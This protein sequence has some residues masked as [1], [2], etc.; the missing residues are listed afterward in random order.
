MASNTNDVQTKIL[1]LEIRYETAIQQLGKYRDEIDK[2]KQVM[3]DLKEAHANGTMSTAEFQKSMAACEQNI[4]SNQQAIATLTRQVQSQLKVEKEQEGSLNQLRASLSKATAE[5][6]A[7]SRAERESAKGKELKNKIN[8]ITAELKGAEEETSRF[9]RNVGNYQEAV[10]GLDKVE[11]KAKGVG[12]A[13]LAMAGITS[14]SAFGKKAEQVGSAYQ[15]QMGKVLAV[16]N[17][18]AVE[19]A[20][21]SAEVERLGSTTRYTAQEAGEAMEYLTRNGLNAVSATGT[22]S[23]VLQLAQSNAIELGEAADIV[24]GQ[25]NAFHMTVSDVTHINDVLSYTCA[26]SATDIRQLNEALRN[27][28]P[29]A[30]TAGVGIEETCAAL[31]TLADNNIKGAD[32]G[33]ILKQAFNGMITSTAKS[34]AAYDALGI[35]MDISTVKANGFVASLKMIMNAGPSVQ[36]LS[37][38]FGRRAVPGVLALTNSMSKLEEKFADFSNSSLV[39]GTAERMFNQSYSQFTIAA[40]GLESA[41]EGFLIQLWSGTDQALRDKFVESGR[42]ID[43]QFIPRVEAAKVA[44][45]DALAEMTANDDSEKDDVLALALQKVQTE[46]AIAEAEYNLAKELA[47]Q[48]YRAEMTGSDELIARWNE[49]A[50]TIKQKYAPAIDSLK[51]EIA[52][53]SAQMEAD[54]E[55]DELS[56]AFTAKKKEYEEAVLAYVEAGEALQQDLG[57]DQ[58][59]AGM[60]GTVQGIL[61]E[62]TAMIQWVKTNID[63]LGTM[64]MAVIGGITLTKLVNHVKV[65]ASTMKNDLITNANAA[66]Q[67]VQNIATKETSLIRRQKQLQTQLDQASGQER[68]MIEQKL[69]INKEQLRQTELAKQKAQLAEQQALQQAAAATT[70]T[71]WKAAMMSATLAVKGFVNASKTAFKGFIL[72]AILSLAF[73]LVMKLWDAFGKGNGV[74]GKLMGTIGNFVSNCVQGLM[75]AIVDTI[76]YFIDMYNTSNI[77]RKAIALIGG[78]FNAI[79]VTIRTAAQNIMNVF[80]T[81]GKAAAALGEIMWNIVTFNWDEVGDSVDKL[82]SAIKTGFSNAKEIGANAAK[83][84]VDGYVGAWEKS[85]EKLEKVTLKSPAKT[86][87]SNAG[88]GSGG[89][90]GSGSGDD[91][92]GGSEEDG[93]GSGGSGSGGGKADKKAEEARRKAEKLEME[94]LANLQNELYK[95]EADGAEKRRKAVEAEY[96]KRIDKLKTQLATEKNLTET[97][98]KAITDLIAVIEQEKADALL[99]LSKEE[100]KKVLEEEIKNNEA[101]LN[102]I[103]KGTGA[104]LSEK[105]R[106]IQA[107]RDAEIA[108][109]TK[110]IADEEERQRKI[111]EITATYE[112][113]RLALI[114]GAMDTE[115]GIRLANLDKKHEIAVQEAEDA[116]AVEQE[117]IDKLREISQEQYDAMSDEQKAAYDRQLQEATEALARRQETLTLINEQYARDTTAA[118]EES[119]QQSVAR[120]KQ[121]LEDRILMMQNDEE[122]RLQMLKNGHVMTEEEE[123]A[124]QQR[125]LE[126]IGGFEAQKL[127]MQAEYAQ[128]AYDALLERGQLSTQTEEEFNR[129]VE[130]A[131]QNNLNAKKAIDDAYVKQEKAK[132]DSMKQLTSSL[133]GL[134][135]T[136]GESNKAFAVMSKVITLAQIAID[137]GRAISAGVASA[138]SMPF[139]SNLAAIATTV[140]TVIANVTTAISTVKSAKFAEGGKVTGPGSGTSDSVPAMLSNGEFVMTAAATRIYEPLLVAMNNIGRGIPMQVMSTNRDAYMSESLTES[141][142]AA[143]QEIQ[144]VVSVTEIN[145]VQSRVRTIENLDTF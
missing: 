49:G 92:G 71:G 117:K 112:Q 72:T 68:L 63:E 111:A 32:S 91:L 142:S 38:I 42:A 2:T 107:K 132:Y 20:Q 21:M 54:P 13:L 100:R 125:K 123:L 14:L 50:E 31:A 69:Q 82:T 93:T 40:K 145:E 56:A 101:R 94:A 96:N 110:D 124:D 9:Y 133:T 121:A 128:Q 105:L 113:Q 35:S 18:N 7:M 1:E 41:W 139:P 44:V 66:S 48:Q 78:T 65:S 27:T 59:A 45:H 24:T 23:G 55:N 98:R 67:Q 119:E 25:M 90:S 34:K 127:E 39:D 76:N 58:Q 37:D 87:G 140:A 52:D 85:D 29:I 141:F 81:I 19:F 95:I 6:D 115:L 102:L 109:A 12:K 10:N 28:A 80:S 108:A 53:L 17:A 47:S 134:L 5:Y 116:I 144:P 86:G 3:K 75:S 57:I 60:A 118:Q 16:T 77:L 129:E 84:I 22:L 51:G 131:R 103:R 114:S 99:K 143:V 122:E 89:G 61:E 73:E 120:Q 11:Q 83:D 88:A 104:E 15:D 4:K 126:A 137:T 79:W 106:G 8:E 130:Q 46:Q 74:F 136:L 36:Q 62:L 70:A 33:T 30:Y 64:I 138:S 97:A 26:T 135:D 43:E